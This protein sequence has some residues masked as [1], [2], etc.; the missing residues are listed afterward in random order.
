M[1]RVR[2]QTAYVLGTRAV[3]QFPHEQGEGNGVDPTLPLRMGHDQ[4][5][6]QRQYAGRGRKLPRTEAAAPR[7][8]R[9]REA[10]REYHTLGGF[11][12]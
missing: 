1:S 11:L 6:A 3:Q 9:L 8:Q 5:K 12:E 10:W 4:Q 2:F 7:T